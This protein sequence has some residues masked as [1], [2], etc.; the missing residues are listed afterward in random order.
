MRSAC[1]LLLLLFACQNEARDE[2]RRQP[3][4]VGPMLSGK[5]P[6]HM[7]NCPSAVAG[8]KT[9]A[10]PTADGVDI[11]ITADDPAA[12]QRI[13]DLARW[14]AVMTEPVWGMPPHTGMRGGPGT[15]GF[16]PIIHAR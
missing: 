12:R 7:R 1:V 15:I 11:T 13:V 4:P 16:C 8:A 3:S 2:A 10:K 14:H 6:K 9:V 5:T